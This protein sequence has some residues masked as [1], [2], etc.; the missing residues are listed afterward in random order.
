MRLAKGVGNG[1]QREA[2]FTAEF[3]R[4]AVRLA[5]HPRRSL[6]AVAR[7]LGVERSVL[8]ATGSITSRQGG[9]RRTQGCL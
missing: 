6:S 3:K 8:K 5:E 7:E 9:T 1:K 4:E 2:G